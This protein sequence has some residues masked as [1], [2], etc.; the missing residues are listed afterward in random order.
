MALTVATLLLQWHT[1]GHLNPVPVLSTH[2]TEHLIL[3]IILRILWAAYAIILLAIECLLLISC[4]QTFPAHRNAEKDSEAMFIEQL[5]RSISRVKARTD[6]REA[7]TTYIISQEFGTRGPSV[8]T[9][10]TNSVVAVA[11]ERAENSHERGCVNNS[12]DRSTSLSDTVAAES[13][14]VSV[15]SVGLLSILLKAQTN[16]V[17]FHGWSSK[18]LARSLHAIERRSVC[19]W[20]WQPMFDFDVPVYPC[21]TRVKW[22]CVNARPSSLIRQISDQCDVVLW[23]PVLSGCAS[24][25]WRTPSTHDTGEIS[26]S[27]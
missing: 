21:D 19:R 23:A 16:S 8:R 12:R 11:V 3:C 5:N 2:D 27:S 10:S 25:R 15:Q 18:W 17:L 6:R 13:P 1:L 22:T 7:G 24:Q 20:N 4:W 26:S 14:T 9:V